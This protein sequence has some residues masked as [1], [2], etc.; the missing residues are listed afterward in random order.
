MTM[1]GGRGSYPLLQR[2]MPFFAFMVGGSY[3]V[4]ILLQVRAPSHIDPRLP[5]SPAR[6]LGTLLHDPRLTLPTT[7][8]TTGKER[9]E[10][11]QG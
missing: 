9:R 10:G 7:T 4:S 1:S 2:G 8:T 3:G 6:V 11:R 5:D